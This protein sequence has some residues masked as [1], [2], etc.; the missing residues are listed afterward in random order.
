MATQT[1]R[2]IRWL[3]RLLLA[4]S[5]GAMAQP[6]VAQSYPSGMIRIVVGGGAGAPPDIITRI[7]ANELGQSEGWRIVVLGPSGRLQPARSS[8][9]RRT[10][11][12]SW[13]SQWALQHL[14]HSCR[15]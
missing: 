7:I 12:R 6:A 4:V 10:D 3:W 15:T 8:S 14:P 2:G 13:P 11:I 5:L 9:N 1:F